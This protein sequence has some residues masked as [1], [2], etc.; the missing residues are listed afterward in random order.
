MLVQEQEMIDVIQN[1]DP[2]SF[3]GSCEKIIVGVVSVMEKLKKEMPLVHLY[4]VAEKKL[5]PI[6]ELVLV[7][8]RKEFH[9]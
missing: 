8:E 2:K 9:L 7:R 1:P 6:L 5:E 3:S 4:L